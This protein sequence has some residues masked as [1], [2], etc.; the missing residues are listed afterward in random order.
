MKWS[1]YKHCA[2][3]NLEWINRETG[4]NYAIR[5]QNGY[6]KIVEVM[7]NTGEINVAFAE[8]W[9]EIYQIVNAMDYMNRYTVNLLTER[10]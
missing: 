3:V 10:S 9:R 8:T 1:E 2:K 5:E 4:K 7:S 6:K